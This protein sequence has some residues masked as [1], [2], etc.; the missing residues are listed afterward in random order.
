MGEAKRRGSH[1]PTGAERLVR[2]INRIWLL[3]PRPVRTFYSVNAQIV[4]WFA[5]LVIG[6]AVVALAVQFIVR[7]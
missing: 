6:A 7:R 3:Y 5:L 4:G 1:L 2:W